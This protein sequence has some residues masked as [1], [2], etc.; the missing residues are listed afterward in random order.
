MF[1]VHWEWFCMFLW[2]LL[3]LWIEKSSSVFANWILRLLLWI[4]RS[5]RFVFTSFPMCHDHVKRITVTDNILNWRK[6][7]TIVTEN[8]LNWR[9]PRTIDIP[10]RAEEA[11]AKKET[12]T[13]RANMLLEQ[14]Y[15][16]PL[17][18]LLPIESYGYTHQIQEKSKFKLIGI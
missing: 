16:V 6:P 13:E 14:S 11:A 3:D 12:F 9:K 4:W 10:E 18:Q 2:P 17:I 15:T 7:R 1:H 5:L 8:I